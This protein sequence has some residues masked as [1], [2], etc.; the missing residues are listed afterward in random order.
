MGF[1]FSCDTPGYHV[2]LSCFPLTSEI[3][4]TL[5]MDALAAIES[6]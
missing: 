1:L 3:L 6:R 5:M 4:D 2:C